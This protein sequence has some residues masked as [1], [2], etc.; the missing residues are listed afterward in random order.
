MRAQPAARLPE[1]HVFQLRW[2]R[3]WH[4]QDRVHDPALRQ[5]SLLTVEEPEQRLAADPGESV[6]VLPGAPLRVASDVLQSQWLP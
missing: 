2:L 4:Q 6:L 5:A 3:G 1:A